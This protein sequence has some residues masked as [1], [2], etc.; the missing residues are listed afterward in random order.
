MNF[1]DIIKQLWNNNWHCFI[2]K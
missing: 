1:D 2:G